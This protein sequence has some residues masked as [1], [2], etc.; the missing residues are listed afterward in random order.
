FA[1]REIEGGVLRQIGTWVRISRK[2][3][4][5]AGAVVNVGGGVGAPG[6]ADVS[7]EVERVALV[8]IERTEVN[9]WRADGGEIRQSPGDDAAAIGDLVGVGEVNLSAMGK[10]GRAQREFPSANQGLGNGEGEEDVGGSDVV[11]VEKIGS[12][13][14]EVVGV[15]DPSTVRNGDAEL[16]F[17]VALAVEWQ[18]AA[19]RRL[20]LGDQRA[21]NGLD[22]RSL[23]VVSVESAECP[24]QARDGDGGAETRAD[25]GFVDGG[26]D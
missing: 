15:K 5:E 11:V 6:E 22:R 4:G 19:L 10:A 7:T 1:E 9:A 18:E 2:S 13:G 17:F 14:F 16:M 21:R 20:A 8:M 25:G 24:T 26:R 3:V 23:V 12:L